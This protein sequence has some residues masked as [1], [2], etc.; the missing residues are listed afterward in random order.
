M[1]AQRPTALLAG[2]LL[3]GCATVPPPET[4]APSTVVAGPTD[5]EVNATFERIGTAYIDIYT[6]LN[7]VAA[8]GLGDHA[9]DAELPGIDAD[10]RRTEAIMYRELLEALGQIDRT[11]L[12]RDNQ[13][14]YAMLKNQLDYA[15]WDLETLQSWAWDPMGYNGT[16]SN[17][18]YS[19]IARDFAPWPQ[20]F[21]SIVARMEKI[22]AFLE[23]SRRQL[24]PARVPK[25][26]AETVSR[27]AA[28]IME[29]VDAAL[30]PEV[31]ASGVPRARFDAA[32]A[33]LKQAVAE[34]QAWIDEVL[35]PGAAGEFRLGPQRYDT[36]MKFALMSDIARP[37]L[38]ARAEAAF[39]EARAEMETIARSFP[40]CATGTQQA[41]IECALAK[42][43]AERPARDQ[44][45]EKAR[46][47]L[48]VAT[49]FT[50]E[51]GFVGMPLGP[52]QVITT[53][54]FMQGVAV[55]YD[56]P[57]GALEKHLPNFYM[58]SPIPEEWTDEQATSFLSE[59]NTYMLHEL[60]IH[61]GMPGHYLQLDHSNRHNSVLR[62][63]L[64]SGPFVEGWA[65][66]SER[67]MAEHGYLGGRATVEGRLYE[68]TML[69]MRLRAIANT[70]LDIGIHTEGM[71][72][73]KAM[74]LMTVGAFQQEREAA[75]KWTRANLSST[76]L[77]SYFTG[78]EEHLAL[79]R[80]AEARWGA[81][82][83]ERRY[84]D[85]LLSHGSPPVKY[86]RALLF[87]LPV[88]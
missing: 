17:A 72:R 33:N 18:L 77:L 29:I 61:E 85:N 87:E 16:A 71:T 80:E 34:Q 68:L 81:D 38:K 13:V 36:K 70:L 40:D 5:A 41:A 74:E 6:A 78:Y 27:Q 14:D 2:L 52:V 11:R 65:V 30:L 55:A 62:A 32:L 64:M 50:V 79:R 59:Y 86:A 82:F 66:Y 7:P 75:G 10:A 60:S 28:G 39:T 53:P 37:E 67:L 23:A 21:E 3:A 46:E 51:K 48:A 24:D 31:E 15:L 76:Q 22:P 56:D 4:G 84:H 63:V 57:P 25:V 45:E 49:A 12:T 9:H 20:R 44:V 35:V 42:T 83:D 43:Y 47:T 8:T 19:L 69:K 1:I 26:H 73:E 54:K 88:E 58:V